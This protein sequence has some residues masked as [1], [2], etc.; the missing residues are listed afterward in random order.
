MGADAP[1]DREAPRLRDGVARL[2]AP[3]LGADEPV[4]AEPHEML[5]DGR[6]GAPDRRRELADREGAGL[7]DLD[8]SQALGVREGPERGAAAAEDSGSDTAHIFKI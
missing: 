4:G 1:E 8:D 7:E 3:P 6:L 5:A 2:P